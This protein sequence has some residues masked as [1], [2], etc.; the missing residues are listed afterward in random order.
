M[1]DAFKDLAGEMCLAHAEV[2]EAWTCAL[3]A[4]VTRA[5]VWVWL[6]LVSRGLIYAFTSTT[7]SVKGTVAVIW[8]SRIDAKGNVFVA[9]VATS[10]LVAV[11]GVY[12]G[13]V[14]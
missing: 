6:V 12:P 7:L 5:Y 3:C 11:I 4:S 13:T 9:R 1:V 8:A 2:V 14:G 10:V